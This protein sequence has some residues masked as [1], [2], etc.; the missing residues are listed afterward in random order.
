MIRSG[1]AIAVPPL[2]ERYQAAEKYARSNGQVRVSEEAFQRAASSFAQVADAQ[3]GGFPRAGYQLGVNMAYLWATVGLFVLGALGFL[4]A[5]RQTT[6]SSNQQ[7][8]SVL[9]EYQR[10][11]RDFEKARTAAY[12]LLRNAVDR[13]DETNSVRSLISATG[14]ECREISLSC[15]KE[16]RR[17]AKENPDAAHQVLTNL[18]FLENAGYYV[19]ERFLPADDF[20]DIYGGEIFALE[21]ILAA[22]IMDTRQ[23]QEDQRIWE[24]FEVLCTAGHVWLKKR[25]P[26]HNPEVYPGWG[27]WR[28]IGRTL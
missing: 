22:Y 4:L 7:R 18:T 2:Q 23:A 14:E 9:L 10:N 25:D 1:F 16:L 19:K 20:V 24:N 5:D 11:W 8:V 21:I 28:A 17:L 15:A 3:A 12:N 27:A 26:F 6:I 13:S